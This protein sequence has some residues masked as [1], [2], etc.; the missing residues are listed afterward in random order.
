VYRCGWRSWRGP[1]AEP[2]QR[3][4][5]PIHQVISADRT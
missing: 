4:A 5:E 1:P 2:Q 3:E